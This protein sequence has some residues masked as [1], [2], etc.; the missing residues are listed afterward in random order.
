[1]DLESQWETFMTEDFDVNELNNFSVNTS[2]NIPH[3]NSV[4]SIPSSSPLKI[5][6]KTK[7]LYL[8]HTFNLK[9]LF[10]TLKTIDYDEEKDGIIKKQI[11]FKFKNKKDV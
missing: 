3:T 6:T 10:F 5:S 7:L 11:K 2:N 4:D 1:M 9:E 8:N